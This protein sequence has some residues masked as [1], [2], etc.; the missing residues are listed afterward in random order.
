MKRLAAV[1]V[2]S[3]ILYGC[4][5]GGGDEPATSVTSPPPP[6]E[7]SVE[8]FWSGTSSTGYDVSLAVLENGETWGV[9]SYGGSIYG[10]LYGHTTVSGS[11]LSGAGT[12]FNIPDRSVTSGSY[13]G[14][15][16]EKSTI[17]VSTSAGAGFTGVYEPAYDQPASLQAVAGTFS[18]TGVSG[19]SPVQAVSVTVTDTG[20]VSVPSSLGCSASG[21]IAP[22]STGKNVFNVTVTF[23]GSTCALG[24]GATTQGI[25]YFD[26]ASGQILVMAMN[27]SKSDG[28]IYIGAK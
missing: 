2:F 15:F 3:A 16:A 18:G 12:D 1:G 21:T 13:T 24:N 19:D 5:G 9:Y 14:T 27:S 4:G 28:F 6:A 17:E 10:A 8:G 11:T 25:A 7:A 26:A 20:Q 23:F 22:R